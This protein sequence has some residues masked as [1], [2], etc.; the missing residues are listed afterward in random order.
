MAA[1]VA[2]A[3]AVAVAL[4]DRDGRRRFEV[5]RLAGEPVA[6]SDRM[7]DIVLDGIRGQAA[8]SS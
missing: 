2:V 1:T 3:V 4:V 5:R 7:L 8:R 6:E